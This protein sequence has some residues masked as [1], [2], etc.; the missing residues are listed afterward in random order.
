MPARSW[1]IPF[2][3]SFSLQN[4]AMNVSIHPRAMPLKPAWKAS[5]RFW[6]L[7]SLPLLVTAVLFHA[8]LAYTV[9]IWL[10]REEYSH[11]LLIPAIS[12]YLVWQKK[13]DIAR[14]PIEQSSLG[15]PLIAAG[16]LLFFLGELSSLFI[17]QQYALVT[18]LA[19]MAW[20][21]F[22][23]PIFHRVWVAIAFLLFAIP[24]P[25]FFF[26]RLSS[27]LQ[28]WSSELGVSF[29]RACNISVFQEGNVI[30]LGA[31]Q[32]Q[33]V[34][35]CSGLR[36]L[37]P[38]MSLA[39]MCAYFFQAPFWKR[40]I[41]FLSSMPITILMNSFRI[42]VIGILVEHFGKSMGEGFLHDFEG[43]IVFMACTAIL[44]GEIWLL[45]R[46]GSDPRPLNEVFGLTVPAP[47]P[48]G[49]RFRRR[50]L[51]RPYWIV[52]GTLVVALALSLSLERREEIRPGRSEFAEFPMTLGP[53]TGSRQRM[54][55]QYVEELKFDDYILATYAPPAAA[56]G[57]PYPVS[58]YSAYYASQR[59]G[60][61]IHSPRSCI[62]GGGWVIESFQPVSLDGIGAGGQPLHANR[63]VIQ[64][65]D[66]R[67]LVYYWFQQRGR[68]LTNEYVVKWYLLWD[69]LT[70]N[71][72]DGALVRYITESP[73]GEDL[74]AADA[75]LRE[76]IG[77]SAGEL[78]RY[79]PD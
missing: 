77:L 65:G 71:R 56:G 14:L 13:T 22:G 19:G 36:Y 27:Q 53:W 38:L 78:D 6:L 44:L 66:D 15:L 37:F 60:A 11:G 52:L 58:L 74:A 4:D 7:L 33:V 47:L 46:I 30:D 5:T 28:L 16:L 39:F 42:G 57:R 26:N 35:A 34:E 9:D 31:M 76:L 18:L 48:P 40:L 25:S 51:P 17:I 61:S 43:W 73:K 55:Q 12:A 68:S 54:E 24:L 10:T 29:I 67:Q 64:K 41:V 23:T 72:T 3:P 1:P 63:L 2:E 20:T 75:R 59:K 8:S 70:R 49:T 69:A 21:L 62:P 50:Q 32:L 79:I 45:A